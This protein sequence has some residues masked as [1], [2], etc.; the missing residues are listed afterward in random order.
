MDLLEL[1]FNLKEIYFFQ[2]EIPKD[3]RPFLLKRKYKTLKTPLEFLRRLAIL[4][5]CKFVYSMPFFSKSFICRMEDENKVNT[6][7]TN[8][9]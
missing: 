3:R 9:V 2:M 5:N 7:L 8:E 6:A 1:C 4:Y